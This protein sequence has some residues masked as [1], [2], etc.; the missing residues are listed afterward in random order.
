MAIWKDINFYIEIA[1][2]TEIA[3]LIAYVN[4][5]L[6]I[7]TFKRFSSA[8]FCVFFWDFCDF[9]RF[10]DFL[11]FQDFLRFPNFR[12]F[13]DFSPFQ[14][15]LRFCDYLRF[16]DFWRFWRLFFVVL[17]SRRFFRLRRFQRVRKVASPRRSETIRDPHLNKKQLRWKQN[18]LKTYLH[19]QFRNKLVHFR[20]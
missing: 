2:L 4:K 12:Y 11:R 3:T 1:A 6:S 20:E 13:C 5:P 16:R 10:H 9:L 8:T 7:A 15:L 14:W 17:S 19:I 18:N